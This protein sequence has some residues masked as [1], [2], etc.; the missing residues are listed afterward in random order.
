MRYEIV[1]DTGP[2]NPREEYVYAA[3][4]VCFDN[5]YNLGDPHTLRWHYVLGWEGVRQHLIDS[6]DAAL[7]LPLYLYDHAGLTISTAPFVGP[8]DSRQVGFIYVNRA[9]LKEEFDNNVVAANECMEEEEEVREYNSYLSGGVWGFL[10]FDDN[11]KEID[12]GWGFYGRDNT[13]RAA[14]EALENLRNAADPPQPS[15]PITGRDEI[16]DNSTTPARDS[17]SLYFSYA[18]KVGVIWLAGDVVSYDGVTA[19]ID[20]WQGPIKRAIDQCLACAEE[21]GLQRFIKAAEKIYG[22][23]TD[24]SFDTD[25][26][27]SLAD[28][29]AWVQTWVWVSNHQAQAAS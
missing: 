16:T 12:S 27:V 17:E 26:A 1:Q 13:E 3:K 25:A 22:G 5:K 29:G 14:L 21:R 7:F 9:I 20:T 15:P 28:G 24:I 2:Y 11:D 19:Q 23:S 4:M 6:Y 8:L 18:G 10:I